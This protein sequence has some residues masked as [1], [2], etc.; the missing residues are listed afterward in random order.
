MIFHFRSRAAFL[1]C[2]LAISLSALEHLLGALQRS[3]LRL[4]PMAI[5]RNSAMSLFHQ[6]TFLFLWNFFGLEATQSHAREIIPIK[7]SIES[8]RPFLIGSN[9]SFEPDHRSYRTTA[10]NWSLLKSLRLHLLEPNEGKLTA[11]PEILPFLR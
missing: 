1:K 10:A 11:F 8:S 4:S 2:F 6:Y 7:L 5:L 3:D 9:L